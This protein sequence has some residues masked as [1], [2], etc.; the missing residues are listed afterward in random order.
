MLLQLDLPRRRAAVRRWRRT[1]TMICHYLCEGAVVVGLEV[2]AVDVQRR[3]VVLRRRLPHPP[4]SNDDVT[5]A[6]EM[7]WHVCVT[8]LKLS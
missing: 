8:K 6:N 7:G 5:N 4:G 2:P 1:A 3:R